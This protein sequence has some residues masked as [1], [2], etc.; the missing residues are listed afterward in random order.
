M[1]LGVPLMRDR[2]HHFC[3]LVSTS[4]HCV[5]ILCIQIVQIGRECN[6]MSKLDTLGTQIALCASLQPFLCPSHAYR[7]HLMPS[8]THRRSRCTALSTLSATLFWPRNPVEACYAC[9]PKD[10]TTLTKHKTTTTHANT[11]TST[12]LVQNSRSLLSVV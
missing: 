5:S 1:S 8:H 6:K 7:T 4:A 3:L 12:T 10:F 11:H 9:I 2:R